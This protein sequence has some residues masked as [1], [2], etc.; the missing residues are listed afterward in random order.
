MSTIATCTSCP[1]LL[2]DPSSKLCE[3]CADA[4]LFGDIDTIA[5]DPFFDVRPAWVEGVW[6][7]ICATIGG[8][9][10]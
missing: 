10:L 2:R 1:A 3:R 5:P 8:M 4:E 9:W 6:V 7:R